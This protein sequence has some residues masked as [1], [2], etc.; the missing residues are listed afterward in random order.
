MNK[1]ALMKKY[2]KKESFTQEELDWM[3]ETDWHPV[4]EMG[5]KPQFIKK[6]EEAE[7]RKSIK[8]KTIEELF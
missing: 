3:E 1:Q 4:D 2:S 6:L 7:K 8:G 5:L